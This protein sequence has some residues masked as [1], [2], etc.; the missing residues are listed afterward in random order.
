MEERSKSGGCKEQGASG[1]VGCVVH[2]AAL[3][4]GVA[5]E[6]ICIGRSGPVKARWWRQDRHIACRSSCKPPS[7]ACCELA[8]LPATSLKPRAC[9]SCLGSC[10]PCRQRQATALCWSALG[11]GAGGWPTADTQAVNLTRAVEPGSHSPINASGLFACDSAAAMLHDG[12]RYH[13]IPDGNG[14]Q[15]FTVH[16]ASRL[17]Q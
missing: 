8:F 17:P 7:T 11:G 9:C 10:Q 4:E 13:T 14:L 16:T 5:E 3:T 6:V 2:G 1:A 12:T 15:G